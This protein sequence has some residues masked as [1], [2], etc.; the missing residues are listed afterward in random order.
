MP[1]LSGT[2]V[3]SLNISSGPEGLFTKIAEMKIPLT[4][5]NWLNCFATNPSKYV[6]YCRRVPMTPQSTT[7]A[8][9]FPDIERLIFIAMPARKE[10]YA[11]PFLNLGQHLF[12]SNNYF[13]VPRQLNWFL[14]VDFDVHIVPALVHDFTAFK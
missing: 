4:T 12:L 3:Q 2:S 7:N 11:W 8:H 13:F 1:V 9:R 10:I 5:L 6:L 14:P